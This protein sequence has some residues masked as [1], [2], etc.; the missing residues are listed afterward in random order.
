MLTPAH[1]MYGC[2]ID[3]IPDKV[4]YEE[5]ET[6][7][8]KRYRYLANRR[9]HFWNRWVRECLA[10]LGEHLKMQDKHGKRN[11]QGGDVVTVTDRSKLQR[12]SWRLEVTFKIINA[13]HRI[14]SDAK[15]YVIVKDGRRIQID[16]PV[17][18][19]VPLE[20]NA[21]VEN[22]KDYQASSLQSG[23]SRGGRSRAAKTEAD[24]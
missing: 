10:N 11:V 4:T 16:R 3:K 1:L 9:R 21:I 6:S 17:Q 22:N 24:W 20:A 7:N 5:N 23:R 14:A 15:I 18:K 12:G 19:L 8:Q 2:R 13:S